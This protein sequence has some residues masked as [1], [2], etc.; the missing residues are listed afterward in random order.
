MEILIPPDLEAW[1]RIFR[2][3][4]PVAETILRGTV[5]FIGLFIAMRLIRR[6]SS[7][8]SLADVLLVSLLGDAA[9]NAMGGGS[10]SVGDGG[11]LV[12]TIMGWERIL[13]WLE[14]R[15]DA[16]R[17][18]FKPKPLPLVRDGRIQRC[19]LRHE[20]ITVE[21][22]MSQLRLGGVERLEDVKSC[23]LEPDGGISVVRRD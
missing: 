20:W 2:P 1:L 21:E 10:A 14:W 15:S 17:R 16:F 23:T 9:Q 7:G 22:L 6:E 18:W 8:L 4:V 11:L 19:N 5:M 3:A 12:A 13:D